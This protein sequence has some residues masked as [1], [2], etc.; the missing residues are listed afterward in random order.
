MVVGAIL[1]GVQ[2]FF[3]AVFANLHPV[4]WLYV[5]YW[6]LILSALAISPLSVLLPQLLK[7]ELR[8]QCKEEGE[9]VWYVHG[10]K[11]NLRPFFKQHPGGSHVLRASRGADITGLFESYHIFI[12]REVLLKML[13]MYEIKE[14]GQQQL[15]PL[16]K[17]VPADPFHEDLKQMVRDHFKGQPKGSHKMTPFHLALCFLNWAVMM[18]LTYHMLT[19]DAKWTIPILGFCSWYMIGNVMH[20]ASHNALVMTPWIN[21]L[22]A[23]TAFPYGISISSWH[24]QHVTSHHVYTNGEQDVDL[25]HFDPIIT[26]KNG[27]GTVHALLHFLRVTLI[28]STAIPHLAI[29]VPYGLLCGQVDP[30]HGHR[31]YDHFRDTMAYRK[32]LRGDILA[33]LLALFGFFGLVYYMQGLAKGLAFHMSIMVVTSYLFSFFTQVSHLQ[34]ECFPDAKAQAEPSFMKRQVTTA[35]DFSADSA[36]WGHVSGGLNTQAIHHCVPSVS[37]MHLRA[38]YPKFRQV[39]RKHS[40]ELKEARS[41]G[42]FLW[43]FIQ[44]SN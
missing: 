13:T 25:Y 24:I 9:D 40:V 1:S 38:L 43:G 33:E 18:C 26:L 7:G 3:Q 21:R 44:F 37:A 27:V 22:L 32:S 15:A 6:T 41:L 29:V 10:R 17:A 20:D 19:T 4:F 35:M 8:W 39:C 30:M 12:D 14:G 34:A 42:A 16:Q 23:H 28:F 11:Y 5:P 2:G 31:M 36:L